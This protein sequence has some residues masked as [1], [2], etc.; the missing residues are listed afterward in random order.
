MQS[1]ERKSKGRIHMK[2]VKK[3]KIKD[4]KEFRVAWKKIVNNIRFRISRL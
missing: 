4:L 1:E 2:G 3:R